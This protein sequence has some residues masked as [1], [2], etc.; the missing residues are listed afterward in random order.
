MM[1][2]TAT[3]FPSTVRNDRSLYSQMAWRA[4]PAAS[5]NCSIIGRRIGGTR[6]VRL[7]CSDRCRARR[8]VDLHRSAVLQLAHRA[9]WTDD[10]LVARFEAGQHFE[11]LLTRDAGLHRQELRFVVLRDEDAFELLAL[12][13]RG[14]F[15][16]LH[17]A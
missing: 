1:E 16:S 2:V 12:L 10:D 7:F 3:M 15:R 8:R 14:K 17:A 4:M 9:E 13:V 5:R 6:P 11:V